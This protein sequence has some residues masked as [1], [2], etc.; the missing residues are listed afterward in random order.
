MEEWKGSAGSC[1]NLSTWKTMWR[2]LSLWQSVEEFECV[3]R[4]V[5][6]KFECMKDCVGQSIRRFSYDKITLCVIALEK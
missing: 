1:G 6:G 3:E 2:I 4:C 5:E